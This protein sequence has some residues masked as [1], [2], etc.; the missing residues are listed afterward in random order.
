M[1]STTTVV[2][3]RPPRRR[4]RASSS[5]RHRSTS[6]RRRATITLAADDDVVDIGRGRR[7]HHRLEQRARGRA[8][9]SRTES[10]RTVHE[11]GQRAGR[12]P[13][14][15]GPAEAAVAVGGRRPASSSAA[16]WLP[17]TQRSPTARRC[18]TARASSNRSITA[19]ESEPSAS[20]DPGVAERRA[21][22]RCRRRGR[23][24]SSGTGTPSTGCAPSSVDVGRRSRW[25]RVH[26]GEALAEQRRAGRAGR[27]ACMP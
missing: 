3:T 22:G 26:R 11:V 2:V 17:R 21:P 19:C 4:D 20:G 15:V 7:E 8:P 1:L 27:S 24:R 16:S 12:D 10:S 25:V 9:A 6:G 23:A 5:A 18:S 13:P 14:A